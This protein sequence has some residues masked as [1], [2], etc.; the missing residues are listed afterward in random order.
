[1]SNSITITPSCIRG[2]F[3][4]PGSK[5]HTI[6]ALAASCAA[7]GISEIHNPL[8]SDDT[9]S[10]ADAIVEFGAEVDRSNS[11]L[12]KVRGVDSN[13]HTPG[14]IVDM[15]N[16][17]T[18]MRLLSA[19]AVHAT[20]EISFDGDASLRTRQMQPLFDALQ[21]LGCTAS[22]ANG[23]APFAIS[24]PLTGG[25][26]KVRGTSSQYLSAL[27][28]SCPLTDTEMTEIEVIDLCEIPYVYITI[29]WLERLGIKVEHTPDLTYF[30]IPGRQKFKA[31]SAVMPGDFSTAA[32]PLAAGL[33]AAADNGEVILHSLDF[34]D[35]QGDKAVFAMLESAGG[36]IEKCGTDVIVRNSRQ[37]MRP[38]EFDLNATPDALPM[39]AAFF[40]TVQGETRLVNVA[41]ARHK[42]CDRIQAMTMEL[43]KMGA[44][45]RE[46]DDG[47]SVQAPSGGLHGAADLDS[48]GD[49]RIAMA[50]SC[51]ALAATTPSV[52]HGIK[53]AAVTYPDFVSDFQKAGASFRL[54]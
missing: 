25:K 52:L 47:M 54:Q 41:Q 40:A 14:R 12:W 1:M 39:L 15:G 26:T 44:I 8:T 24:G 18:G 23:K 50:L 45:V 11:K 32:F 20:G 28:F 7:N 2:E 53:D 30:R 6:R 21:Q 31:F 48:H 27:L 33:L 43:R 49:H 37:N 51:A 36:R 19:L 17:G 9:I 22:S 29:N 35:A 3:T 46:Y 10:T 4:V 38:G 13:F 42:E 34:G 16:S 5:S